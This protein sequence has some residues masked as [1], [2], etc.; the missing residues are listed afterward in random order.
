MHVNF[1]Y[2]VAGWLLLVKPVKL[3]VSETS[4]LSYPF[5]AVVDSVFVCSA[6]LISDQYVL[7]PAQCVNG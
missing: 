5:H 6:L 1:R 4:P 7:C 2:I 3:T